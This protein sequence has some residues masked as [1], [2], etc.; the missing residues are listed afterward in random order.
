MNVINSKVEKVREKLRSFVQL[1]C[2]L[3]ELWPLICPEKCI[4]YNFVLT[5]ARKLSLLEQFT[6]FI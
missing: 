2:F 5:S 6:Y 1:L 4:F 3:P